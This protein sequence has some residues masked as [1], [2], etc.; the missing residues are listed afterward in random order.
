MSSSPLPALLADVWAD[1]PHRIAG[2]DG[3]V[4]DW[5]GDGPLDG[6]VTYR[7]SHDGWRSS[8]AARGHLVSRRCYFRSPPAR[9]R[10]HPRHARR[11]RHTHLRATSIHRRSISLNPRSA[12]KDC[13]E[14]RTMRS[15]KAACA[16]MRLKGVAV[17][18]SGA[19]R[20]GADLL[21]RRRRSARDL[22]RAARRSRESWIRRRRDL[23]HLRV[24]ADDV[25]RRTSRTAVHP[26]DGRVRRRVRSKAC[27]RPRRRIP[28]ACAGGPT[29][30]ASFSTSS[31]ARIRTTDA[32]DLPFAGRLDLQRV[33]AFGHSAGGQAAATACQVERRLRACL[34]QDGLSAMAP[35]YLD[36]NGWGMDQAFMLISAIR[37]GKS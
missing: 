10:P 34:N 26:V 19:P 37:R 22:Q 17:R 25:P 3:T 27:R 21:A 35:Y 28:L 36:A 23:A 14:A 8:R 32:S 2:A 5:K 11:P 16:R 6:C 4:S 24:R 9:A 29:T 30:S 7:A 15:G 12:C 20:A 1:A 31:P 13:C 33:G 18:A